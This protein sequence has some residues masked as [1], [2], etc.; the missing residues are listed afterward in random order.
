[1]LQTKAKKEEADVYLKL[2]GWDV[3]Q[4]VK[5]WW[6]DWNWEKG[7]GSPSSGRVKVEK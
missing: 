5:K 4:A 1:M 3:E 7:E 6:E 2:V